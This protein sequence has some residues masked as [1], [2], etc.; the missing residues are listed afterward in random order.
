MASSS[1]ITLNCLGCLR[2]ASQPIAS[3]SRIA[4]VAPFSTSAS[5]H[6]SAPTPEHATA[7]KPPHTAAAEAPER[8]SS[9]NVISRGRKSAGRGR[10]RMLPPFPEWMAGEATHYKRP[11][12]GMGPNW[13]GDT[14]SLP[15]T[16]STLAIHAHT[17]LP[18]ASSWSVTHFFMP[19][20][21]LSFLFDLKPFPLNPAFNPPPP[22]RASVKA[23]IW[24]LHASDPAKW[25][26]PALSQKFSIG[27]ERMEAVLRLK[28][29]ETEWASQV[30]IPS[31][32]V[33]CRRAPFH[34]QPAVPF[35][36]PSV[37]IATR[38]RRSSRAP[39][40]FVSHDEL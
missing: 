10:P 38:R 37:A 35:L 20:F 1:R 25:T 15:R 17:P 8:S 39:P 6:Y 19:L 26:I 33:W 32:A 23:E 18:K 4:L 11:K 34:S 5:H 16:Q 31:S 14:V 27:K 24:Q 22:L 21:L 9:I 7:S 40:P 12:P 30:S 13:I 28:A 3:S 29:L 2:A 36:R